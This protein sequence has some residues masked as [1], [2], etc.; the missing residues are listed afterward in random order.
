MPRP[1]GTARQS[2]YVA[3][4]FLS[5]FL[6]FLLQPILARML[7][8]VYGGS[9]AVWNTCMVFFQAVLLAGYAYAHGSL[10]RFGFARQSL[11]HGV[12]LVASL[13]FLPH[14]LRTTTASGSPIA[15]ILITL[16]LLAGIPFFVLSTNS[17]LTQRWFSLG[18]FETS[19]DPFWLY[20]A[21]NAGSLIALLSYPIVV[22]P[23]FGLRAQL[24]GWAIGY[25]GFVML[26]VA[27]MLLARPAMSAVDVRETAPTPPVPMRR[28]LSWIILAAVASSLLL[29]IT[30]EITTDV[31]STPL[32]WVVP[33]SI[34]LLTFIIAFSP[35]LRPRRQIVSFATMVG[36]AICFTMLVIPTLFPLWFALVAQLAT[37]FFGAL[38]CNADL[39]DERP[40]AA[41]LTDF[42]LWIAL[43]GVIG[44]I[45]N[46]IVAP[47]VFSTVVEYPLTLVALALLLRR[48]QPGEMPRRTRVIEWSPSLAM[49]AFA[50]IAASAVLSHRSHHTLGVN[51]AGILQWQFTPVA[52]LVAGALLASQRGAFASASALSAAFVI[53]G[54][55]FIDPIVDH[56]RSFFGISRVTDNARERIMI[57]GVT[58]HGSQRHDP[59]FRDIPTS[60]Y[61]PNGPLGWTVAHAPANAEIGVVGLGAGALAALT[62]PGQRITYFEIDPLV[63]A[64]ARRDF[65]FLADSPARTAIMIGDGRQLLERVPDDHFD[66]LVLD[67]FSGDAIP[68]HL[69]TQEALA[70]DMR[71]LK[72]R[73]LLVVHI[74]NRYADL[75]RV[76]RGLHQATGQPI[77]IDQYLPS[78]AEQEQGVRPTVAVALARDPA[79]YAQLA[80]MHQWFWLDANGA[81][82]HWTDDHV[83]LLGVLDKNI[84]KP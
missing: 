44:G 19:A 47:L 51:S 9:P 31:I 29:S 64:M 59:R 66:L 58:V 56:G 79:V 65:T 20:A 69:L 68:T 17:S 81:A 22:E 14:A 38:L 8:P 75:A 33:L 30:M 41:Q 53:G 52:L 60:Y 71:K 80:P 32:F 15:S 45:A 55:T 3:S 6:L 1:A 42:Y 72:P 76:F 21:S 77:V 28:R 54:L 39:A 40:G 83:N 73:G 7:L 25:V 13:L 12:L 26:S 5:A 2:V 10:R 34:Y 43:G 35:S 78:P 4:V 16:T 50:G 18:A 62:H 11:V 63:V 70:L 48:E 46:S 37:L 57:H 84:L 23:L 61:Y 36:I 67:A 27:A 82:V 49:L 24:R 74:S